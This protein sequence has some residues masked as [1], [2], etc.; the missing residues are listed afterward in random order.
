MADILPMPIPSAPT[1]PQP[2]GPMLPQGGQM[3]I[4]LPPQLQ[5]VMQQWP[6]LLK[7]LGQF[8]AKV[9]VLEAKPAPSTTPPSVKLAAAFAFLSGFSLMAFFTWLWFYAGIIFRL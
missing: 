1:G 2:Q 8:E 9:L 5:E 6:E 4:L 7:R 3:Q